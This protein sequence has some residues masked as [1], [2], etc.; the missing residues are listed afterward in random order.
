MVFYGVGM[1]F[2][3]MRVRPYRVRMVVDLVCM[4][5]NPVRVRRM[6]MRARPNERLVSVNGFPVA[7]RCEAGVLRNTVVMHGLSVR[8]AR[9]HVRGLER[10]SAGGLPA[11]GGGRRAAAGARCLPAAG[12]RCLSTAGGGRLSTAA[13]DSFLIRPERLELDIEEHFVNAYH[14]VGDIELQFRRMRCV[15]VIREIIDLLVGRALCVCL[16]NEGAALQVGNTARYILRLVGNRYR[17]VS[18]VALCI[19]FLNADDAGT[20]VNSVGLV[21]DADD[22]A[23]AEL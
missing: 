8:L 1:V 7:C 20:E 17:D 5:G 15:G 19:R 4:C 12:A 21:H 6:R 16:G 14:R 9:E 23:R 22:F 18:R 10:R 2:H 13:A 11:A 3:R